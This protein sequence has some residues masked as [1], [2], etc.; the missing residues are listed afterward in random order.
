[1]AEAFKSMQGVMQQCILQAVESPDG[2]STVSDESLAAE[3]ASTL[4]AVKRKRDSRDN[5]QNLN[6]QLDL[7]ISS[8]QAMARAA[9]RRIRQPRIMRPAAA[10]S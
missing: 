10:R 3:M 5:G 1:M 2:M 4:K 9:K 6:D 8:K 7:D